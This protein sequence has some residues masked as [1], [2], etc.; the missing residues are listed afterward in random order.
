VSA[1]AKG[2]HDDR[3]NVKGP[4]K[5][6]EAVWKRN[7]RRRAEGATGETRGGKKSTTWPPPAWSRCS[8]PTVGQEGGGVISRK[9]LH[10]GNSLVKLNQEVR[11][12]GGE[13]EDF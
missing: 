13:I 1:A 7:C 2:L 4:P 5:I 11:E 6:A 8:R 3:R 10:S 12:A 9:L